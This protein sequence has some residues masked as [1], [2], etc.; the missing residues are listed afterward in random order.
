MRLSREKLDIKFWGCTTDQLVIL[1]SDIVHN[2][3]VRHTNIITLQ[4]KAEII[5]LFLYRL[6]TA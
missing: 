3:L 1:M 4:N 5:T 2:C 6:G